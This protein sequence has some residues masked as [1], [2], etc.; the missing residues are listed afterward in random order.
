MNALAGSL[1]DFLFFFTSRAQLC[2]GHAD[3]CDRPYGNVTFLGAHDSFAASGNPFARKGLLTFFFLE[4][5]FFLPHI[6][7]ARTQE[8]DVDTQLMMGVRM[9]QAQAHMYVHMLICFFFFRSIGPMST[10]RNRKDLHLC[11]TS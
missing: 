1:F 3:L 9:L 6:T 10:S 11:H 4:N 8:V 7:V 5:I 2:N